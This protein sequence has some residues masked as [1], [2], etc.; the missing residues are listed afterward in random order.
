M[1][2]NCT[3][4][5][6]TRPAKHGTLCPT[7]YQQQRRGK[8]LRAIRDASEYP[9]QLA[10]LDVDEATREALERLAQREGR[11]VAE[12]H[13]RLLRAGLGLTP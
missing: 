1:A 12:V 13:R 11:P 2:E 9:V 3:G 10:R 6:C 4:P 8:P 5:S 7:H